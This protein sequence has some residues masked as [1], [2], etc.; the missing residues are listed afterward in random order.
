MLTEAKVKKLKR[1]VAPKLLALPSVSGVGICDAE[2][3]GTALAV[4][5]V[6]AGASLS[7]RIELTVQRFSSEVPVRVIAAGPFAKSRR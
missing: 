2:T 5:V 7:K 1:L 6:K 3:G 4:Y